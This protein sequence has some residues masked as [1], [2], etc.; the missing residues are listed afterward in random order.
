MEHA[1]HLSLCWLVF[2]LFFPWYVHYLT[3]GQEIVLVSVLSI[4]QKESFKASLNPYKE[5][6]IQERVNGNHM[7]TRK[8][9]N[10]ET[11]NAVASAVTMGSRD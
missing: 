6:S 5:K 3:Q 4:K 2:F 11:A 1:A 7:F 9:K 10:W 8:E